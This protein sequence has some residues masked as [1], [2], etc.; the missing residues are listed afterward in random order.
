MSSPK[1]RFI[2]FLTFTFPVLTLNFLLISDNLPLLSLHHS[3][4]S[5]LL[6]ESLSLTFNWV[7]VR[8]L[9]R[10]ESEFKMQ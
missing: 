9:K 2:F 8:L 3:L 7:N 1:E 10:C 5:Y 4:V 6:F